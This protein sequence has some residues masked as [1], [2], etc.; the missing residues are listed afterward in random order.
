MKR[1]L[2]NII[3][4]VVYIICATILCGACYARL[5]FWLEW[6][7][8]NDILLFI[9]AILLILTHYTMLK[10]WSQKTVIADATL[11]SLR[12]VDYILFSSQFA[13]ILV[14]CIASFTPLA[15]L[16][17]RL[18]LSD[19]WPVLVIDCLVLIVRYYLSGKLL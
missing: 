2:L 13:I 15:F 6:T 1:I 3:F 8:S 7:T 16:F 10:V 5:V 18:S 4:A 19:V 12:L 17:F 14:C 11:Y 9:G